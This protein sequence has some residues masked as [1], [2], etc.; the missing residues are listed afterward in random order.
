VQSGVRTDVLGETAPSYFDSAALKI[1]V[2]RSSEMSL[3]NEHISLPRHMS[4]PYAPGGT[5]HNSSSER[6]GTSLGILMIMIEEWN[7]V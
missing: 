3:F 4:L 5:H 7:K 1:R 2:L 6:L